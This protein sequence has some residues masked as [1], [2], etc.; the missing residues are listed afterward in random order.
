MVEA[1]IEEETKDTPKV[2]VI[3]STYRLRKMEYK[4]L[5]GGKMK[6]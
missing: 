2:V 5:Q 6:R 1:N 4:L 3:K